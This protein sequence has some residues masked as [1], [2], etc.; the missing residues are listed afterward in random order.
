L[1]HPQTKTGQ[2]IK[3]FEDRIQLLTYEEIASIIDRLSTSGTRAQ[4]QSLLFDLAWS[5]TPF[6]F[7]V[8]PGSRKT[9]W[10]PLKND[11]FPA[12]IGV[13]I[14][15]HEWAF[16]PFSLL[17]GQTWP[18]KSAVDKLFEMMVHTNPFEIARAYLGVIQEVAQCMENVLVAGGQKAEDIEIDFDSLFPLIMICVFTFGVGEWMNVAMYAIS[19]SEHACDDAELQFAMTYLEGLVTQILALDFD[20]LR[21]KGAEMRRAWADDQSDPLGLH[22]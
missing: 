16:T 5:I 3:R 21:S 1:L 6:P 19:F 15:N 8:S 10:I 12:V 17:S 9:R 7:G 4:V 18:F 11:L 22:I 14:L 20:E 13:T 2:I